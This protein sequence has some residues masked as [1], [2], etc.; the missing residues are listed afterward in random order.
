MPNLSSHSP[1]SLA[2]TVRVPWTAQPCSPV[3]DSGVTDGFFRGNS[4]DIAKL[5][6]ISPEMVVAGSGSDDILGDRFLG[7][8]LYVLF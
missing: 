7:M 8:C 3:I 6:G 4:A 2:L 1:S 5:H